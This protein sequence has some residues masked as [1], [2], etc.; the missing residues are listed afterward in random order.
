[1]FLL[2]EALYFDFLQIHISVSSSHLP[3]P[4]NSPSYRSVMA[5][6]LE[7]MCY[8]TSDLFKVKV[9]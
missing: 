1:M 8:F 7:S 9:C 6:I 5:Y 2:T 4:P 3:D